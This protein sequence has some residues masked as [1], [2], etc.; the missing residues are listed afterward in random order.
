[1]EGSQSPSLANFEPFL[2]IL[3]T[4]NEVNPDWRST[5]SAWLVDA[6]CLYVVACG[7][8]SSLW[9]DSVDMVNVLAFLNQDIPDDRYVY[10]TF[11]EQ[12]DEALFFAKFCA[13]HDTV[14]I[15]N[16]LFLDIGQSGR[17]QALLEMFNATD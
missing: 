11:H 1:M 2:C 8:D 4:A 16:L 13:S 3:L 5:I 9:D 15:Q 7:P 6:G 14:D 12:L 17:Q 10:T